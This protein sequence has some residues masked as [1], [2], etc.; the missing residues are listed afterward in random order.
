MHEVACPP[1][2]SASTPL[3]LAG[4]RP[5]ATDDG[6]VAAGIAPRVTCSE[7][8]DRDET[9]SVHRNPLKCRVWSALV[10]TVTRLTEALV[11]WR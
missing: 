11:D 5:R 2:S 8:V 10:E 7:T 3:G 1:V 4:Y 9:G 6:A